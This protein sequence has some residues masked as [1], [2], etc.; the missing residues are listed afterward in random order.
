MIVGAPMSSPDGPLND[1]P[2]CHPTSRPSVPMT[3]HSHRPSDSAC[4]LLAPYSS[5][6]WGNSRISGPGSDQFRPPSV[7][8]L[9]ATHQPVMGSVP[10]SEKSS[11]MRPSSSL[12][13]L[14]ARRASPPMARLNHPG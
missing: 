13:L 2:A 14:S 10:P 4:G 8:V 1:T 7:V 3:A 5:V 12:T 11:R 6:Q 9:E